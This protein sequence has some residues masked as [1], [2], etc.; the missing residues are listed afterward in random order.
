MTLDPRFRYVVLG[1]GRQGTAAAYDLARLGGATRVVMADAS[2]DA[3]RQAAAR[4]NDL[5]GREVAEA[6]PV[7]AAQRASV[8]DVLAGAHVALSAVPY[9]FNLA[10][11]EA[12]IAAGV[13][14]CDL[15]GNTDVVWSQ[16][17]L[18][19]AARRAGVSVVPDCGMGPGLI[20][21]MGVHV[22][23]LLDRAREVHLYDGGLPQ[24]PVAP[25]GYQLTFH[26]NG[27]TN[28]YDG[29]ATFIR[30]GKLTAVPTFTELETIEFPPLGR[31]EAFVISGSMSTTPHTHLG[32][33]E[34]Y[35]NKVLRYPGHFATF[36]A[37]KRLGLFSEQP[38]ELDGREVVPRQLYHRLL[39][40]KLAAPRI[41]DVCVMRA[42][43]V[44]EMDGRP[45][46]VT[47]D[48]VDRYD[49]VTGFTA[50]ERLTGWHAAIMMA[51]QARGRI[52]PGAHRMEQAV[53]AGEVLAE[54]ERRGIPHTVAWEQASGR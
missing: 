30:D 23:D 51:L 52:E 33:L 3:A 38:V 27:L 47:L 20:N 45:A 6:A 17:R 7:D 44:G 24:D 50:M 8:A 49:P 48:L 35:E 13:S 16:L 26:V 2:L 34:R 9:V 41:R 39:E 14:L 29:D 32:R 5:L 11:S 46:R 15:G 4:V 19:E 12:C 21:H 42:L 54:L 10:L 53:R 43:G 37:Y 22:M 36:E 18:G 25:W 1:A 28:E 40:P 31:L